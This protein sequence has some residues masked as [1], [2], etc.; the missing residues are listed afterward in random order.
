[1]LGDSSKGLKAWIKYLIIALIIWLIVCVFWLIEAI[2]NVWLHWI[3]S[4]T[5]NLLINFEK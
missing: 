1:M 5:V 3:I 2:L 4:Y